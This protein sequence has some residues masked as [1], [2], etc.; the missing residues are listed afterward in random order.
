MF[1]TMQLPDCYGVHAL[2]VANVCIVGL[3][4]GPPYAI[5]IFNRIQ[6]APFIFPHRASFA[7]L[8][9]FRARALSVVLKRSAN[10]QIMICFRPKC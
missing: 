2:K 9:L 8:R 7:F 1:R 4:H 6:H 3:E 10:G 5:Y